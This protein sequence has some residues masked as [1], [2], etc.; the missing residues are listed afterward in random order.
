MTPEM[1]L[2]AQGALRK[3][4]A[5]QMAY[6]ATPAAHPDQPTRNEQTEHRP[7]LLRRVVR[8]LGR[9]IAAPAKARV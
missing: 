6:R 5:N 4:M 2:V 1:L 3:H 7:M 9:V 8:L